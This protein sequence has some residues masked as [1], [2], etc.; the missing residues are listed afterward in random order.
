MARIVLTLKFEFSANAVRPILTC[1][2]RIY[3]ALSELDASTTPTTTEFFTTEA[4]DVAFPNKED[5]ESCQ[6]FYQCEQGVTWVKKDCGPGTF[7]N[8]QTQVCDF[9]ATVVAI[10]P[11]CKGQ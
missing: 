4:C 8:P 11:S 10:K 3:V 5:P 1:T 7:Y 6:S 2:R 9:E